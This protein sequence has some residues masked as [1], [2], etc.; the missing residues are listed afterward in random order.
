MNDLTLPIERLI[1]PQVATSTVR[2]Q[3]EK[4]RTAREYAAVFGVSLADA[5]AVFAGE[6]QPSIVAPTKAALYSDDETRRKPAVVAKRILQSIAT[7]ARQGIDKQSRAKMRRAV[8]CLGA[9]GL[10][11]AHV[12]KLHDIVAS[13]CAAFSIS[14]AAVLGERRMFREVVPRHMAMTMASELCQAMTGSQIGAYFRRDHTALNHARRRHAERMERWPEYAEAYQRIRHE[15]E[16][17]AAG[18]SAE[19]RGGTV[20]GEPG[21]GIRGDAVSVDKA[22]A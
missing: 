5:R 3:L 11:A 20:A 12:A 10:H 15:V 17:L 8:A 22:A 18:G 21:D 2:R 13:V 6:K 4:P 16:R 1:V 14:P 7:D 9:A 19:V